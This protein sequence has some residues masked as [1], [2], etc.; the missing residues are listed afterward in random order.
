MDSILKLV[1][2]DWYYFNG[3]KCPVP[4]GLHPV[5]IKHIQEFVP[6][7]KGSHEYTN[8]EEIKQS[9]QV[10]NHKKVFVF[11]HNNFIGYHPRHNGNSTII[12]TE[13]IKDDDNIYLYV[14]EI[15]D[16]P[17]TLYSL[18][19]FIYNEEKYEYRFIDIIPPTILLHLRSGR[20]KL[21]LGYIYELIE[22]TDEIYHFCEIERTM[23][24]LGIDSNNIIVIAGSNMINPITKLKFTNGGLLMGQQM[25]E[26]MDR[27]PIQT[28][29]GYVSDIVRESDLDKNKIRNKKFLCF[30][31]T[32]KPHRFMLAY[33]ALKHK[34]LDN[35]I[36]SFIGNNPLATQRQHIYDCLCHY[37]DDVTNLE[38][39][40]TCIYNLMPYEID[41]HHLSIDQKGS[42]GI[43]NTKKELYLDTY[44][45]ITSETRFEGDSVF[46][47][48]KTY[49]P[50]MN[51]QPF[52]QVGTAYSLQKLH[53]LGF[54]TFHPFI[55]ESYDLEKDHKTRMN[56]IETEIK[57][58]NNRSIN[59]IHD[60][61]YSITD[62]L[63]HNQATFH[64]MRKINPYE[65][66]C[67]DIKNFYLK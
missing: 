9:V 61:Y 21:V 12:S 31:R 4:N 53:D 18:L 51:L 5:L 17:S 24:N 34:L 8:L 28:G 32:M 3:I 56:M 2:N 57:K 19:D 1:Y 64:D 6:D 46:L 58:F 52:I 48:E 41:T 60:W 40:S 66:P 67:R 62:V 25:A 15:R 10:E 38:E 42:F 65:I 36:F 13:D 47:S 49:R 26:Q 39:M 7:Y 43:E 11:D 63:L 55:D 22:N 30:N 33:I 23:N 37:V 35:N 45:H 54:K 27:Y 16:S 44:L 20:V 14:V 29:L 59:E 50:L